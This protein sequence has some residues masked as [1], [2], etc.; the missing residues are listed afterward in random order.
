MNHKCGDDLVYRAG[1]DICTVIVHEVFVLMAFQSD[2]K[3]HIFIMFLVSKLVALFSVC[4]IMGSYDLVV[5]HDGLDD[6]I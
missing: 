4:D 5:T 2:S 3:I 6:D 1:K